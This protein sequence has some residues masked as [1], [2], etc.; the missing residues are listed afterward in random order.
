MRKMIMLIV[1]MSV[2][3]ALLGGTAEASEVDA[4]TLND[5]PDEMRW[6]VTSMGTDIPDPPRGFMWAEDI[7][8]IPSPLYT[9]ADVCDGGGASA[10]VIY[11]LLASGYTPIA[12]EPCIFVKP[13]GILV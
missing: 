2:A 11:N 8:L 7:T 4:I 13:K 12:E 9:H 5:M 6:S 10:D 1:L 3:V